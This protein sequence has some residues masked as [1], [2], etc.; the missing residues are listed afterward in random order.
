MVKGISDSV[1]STE[2]NFA[3]S[4]LYTSPTQNLKELLD[5]LQPINGQNNFRSLFN[6]VSNPFSGR[7]VMD[8]AKI[9]LAMNQQQDYPPKGNFTLQYLP[10]QPKG[11]YIGPSEWP[12]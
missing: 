5:R 9:L 1:K 11:I 8:L 2:A 12:H 4:L 6:R 7:V 10:L 3:D